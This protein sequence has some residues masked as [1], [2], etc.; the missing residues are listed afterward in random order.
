MDPGSPSLRVQKETTSTQ[1]KKKHGLTVL[2]TKIGMPTDVRTQD[3]IPLRYVVD[4]KV[5]NEP[6][7]AEKYEH[8]DAIK[9]ACYDFNSELMSD[10]R[11]VIVMG[12]Q[13][14][15]GLKKIVTKRGFSIHELSLKVKTTMFSEAPTIYLALDV[16]RNIRQVI[17][18][19]YHGEYIYYNQDEARGALWDLMWNMAC[20]FSGVPVRNSG[21]FAWKAKQV[22][23]RDANLESIA[24]HTLGWKMDINVRQ[25][26]KRLGEYFPPDKII[27]LFPDL[28]QAEP[29]LVN[30]I[31]DAPR[32]GKRPS[33][34]IERYFRRKAARNRVAKRLAEESAEEAANP[35]PP[36]KPMS[37]KKQAWN[38]SETMQK[39]RSK[40]GVLEKKYNAFMETYEVRTALANRGLPAYC[41]EIENIDDMTESYE[42]MGN[43][44][45]LRKQLSN[46]LLT[47][48]AW[49]D[50]KKWPRGL[51]FDEDKH[52]PNPL[53]DQKNPCVKLVGRFGQGEKQRLAGPQ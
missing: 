45:D 21:Y 15:D 25:A 11:F 18:R 36:K 3:L 50:E 38:T 41:R 5:T 31:H 42:S 19:L 4:R 10:D 28:L 16:D 32:T 47:R 30:E 40:D 44:P 49:Y 7:W 48:V 53:K 24:S 1:R 27:R 20:E 43:D 35:R 6:K 29:H 13:P 22:V 33:Y 46:K 14:F 51:P 37:E 2:Q 23:T 26:E 39:A 9:K 17:F 52:P 34:P 12:Q 8:W